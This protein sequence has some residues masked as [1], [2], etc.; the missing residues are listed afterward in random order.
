MRLLLRNVNKFWCGFYQ[1]GN[2]I[3]TVRQCL[4][5]ATL[6]HSAIWLVR[7]LPRVVALRIWRNGPRSPIEDSV[8]NLCLRQAL[9]TLLIF[10]IR[11]RWRATQLRLFF[12][13][14]V[15]WR[16]FEFNFAL[17]HGNSSYFEINA[18]MVA[19]LCQLDSMLK[20]LVNDCL[21]KILTLESCS[22]CNNL[23]VELDW[24]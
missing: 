5:L 8:D 2:W 9:W 21:C 4:E 17:S 15:G 18:H 19:Q 22:R 23:P 1:W 3:L 16:A 14:S 13:V 24:A 10:W 11:R 20:D 7:V 12:L 6:L